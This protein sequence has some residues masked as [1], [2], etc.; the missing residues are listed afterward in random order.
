[1][2]CMLTMFSSMP[3]ISE[4]LTTLR[5]PSLIRE[6][7]TTM[8]MAETI[9]WRTLFSGRLRLLI[10]TMDSSLVRASLGVLA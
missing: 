8:E 10:A 7:W 2:S 9:C 3:V 6:T 1:M 5:E 4:M